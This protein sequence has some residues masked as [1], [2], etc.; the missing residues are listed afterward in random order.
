M[1]SN[2]KQFGYAIF[3]L[4]TSWVRDWYAI[5]VLIISAVTRFRDIVLYLKGWQ[6]F[7]QK[8]IYRGGIEKSCIWYYR[9]PEKITKVFAEKFLSGLKVFVAWEF[10]AALGI[11]G[12][13]GIFVGFGDFWQLA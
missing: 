7:F 8:N 11:F 9:V 5:K 6:H 3:G 4:G 13:L 10:L 12:D 1:K 2:F